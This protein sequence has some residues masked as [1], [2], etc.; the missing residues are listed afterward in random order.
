MKWTKERY[1][2]AEQF[3]RRQIESFGCN[4]DCDDTMQ[5]GWRVY[6]L[7]QQDYSRVS[8]CCDFESYVNYRFEVHMDELRYKRNERLHIESSLSLDQ[9]LTNTNNS[10]GTTFF[11][12]H[13]DF[14]K[15]VAL[16]DFEERQG[17]EKSRILRLM[18]Y[19][20]TDK[21]IMRLYKIAPSR[22][23]QHVGELQAAFREWLNI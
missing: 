9:P 17:P 7:A 18:R 12:S 20:Y 5:D 4:S 21:E 3:I 8:G 13:G 15:Y 22:Y 6:L 16:Q 19:Q 1:L 10:I 2:R 11:R 23:Y 14:T